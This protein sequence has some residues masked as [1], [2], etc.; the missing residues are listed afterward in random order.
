MALNLMNSSD[1]DCGDHFTD[2]SPIVKLRFS[3]SVTIIIYIIYLLPFCF[4]VFGNI[5]VCLIFFQQK[6]LRSITNTFLMNL[7]LNDLIVLCVSI[8]MTIS[9]ALLEHWV[10]GAFLCKFVHF[11]PTLTALVSTFTV[12]VIAVERWFF[13]VIKKKFDRRCTIIILILLW[14]VSILIAIPEFIAREVQVIPEQPRLPSSFPISQ[15]NSSTNESTHDHIAALAMLH[16]DKCNRRQVHYCLSDPNVWMRTFSYIV[17]IVQYLVPFLFVSVSCYSISR[18]LK[19]RMKQMR[20]YQTYRPTNVNNNN[21]NN[22]K[23]NKRQKKDSKLQPLDEITEHE[24]ASCDEVSVTIVANETKANHILTRFRN[25]FH[26]HETY[27]DTIVLDRQNH[28]SSSSSFVGTYVVPTPRSQSHSER[29]FHRSKKL[30][31]C[32]AALFTISWLPLTVLQIYLEHNEAILLNDSDFVYGYLLIPS[33]L[34]SSLSAWM[35]PVIY[36]YINRSFRREFYALYPCCYKLASSSSS[37]SSS[38]TKSTTTASRAELTS[39]IPNR[40]DKQQLND[41]DEEDASVILPRTT[42][43]STT[44]FVTFADIEKKGKPSLTMVNEHI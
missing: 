41:I 25:T 30:L 44:R 21:N 32:V 36:N 37:S 34:I 18:F 6:K 20:V 35:N 8:P 29:R 7:C 43:K 22:N 12:A 9:A 42:N 13:I 3:L 11:T 10:F 5:S 39:V 15:I 33:Y 16:M 24:S 27:Q 28:R 19:R 17:I 2:N 1:Q 31:I 23:T 4:G 26:Q 14:M 40:L 38:S